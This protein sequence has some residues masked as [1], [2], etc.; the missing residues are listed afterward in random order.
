MSLGLIS[1]NEKNLHPLAGLFVLLGVVFGSLTS[2]NSRSAQAVTLAT[3]IITSGPAEIG[4]NTRPTFTFSGPSE[5]GFQCQII[6]A[7]SGDNNFQSCAS[8]YTSKPLEPG[9]YEFQVYASANQGKGVSEIA[10]YDF[11]IST[12][13]PEKPILRITPAKLTNKTS[14]L[15]T[16]RLGKGASGGLCKLDAG[17]LEPCRTSKYYRKLSNGRHTFTV[18]SVTSAGVRSDL[19]ATYSWVV[20]TV[21][22]KITITRKPDRKNQAK[23][24]TFAWRISE[25]VNTERSVCSLKKTVY[26]PCSSPKTFRPKRGGNTFIVRV[27]DRAGNSGTAVYFFRQMR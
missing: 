16:F 20:D 27:R 25:A 7:G 21:K 15:I 19:A 3:P 1:T 11:E 12:A 18:Y 4:S 23:R 8:P 26:K 10:Y 17:K 13:K 24:V 5:A 9:E 22:P 2:A 6:E 14:A